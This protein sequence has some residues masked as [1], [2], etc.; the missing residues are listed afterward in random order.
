[1]DSG[2]EPTLPVAVVAVG[3]VLAGRYEVRGVLGAG[4]M[5]AVYRALDRE[6]EEEIALKVLRPELAATPDALKR[7]RREVKLARRVT[8]P[9]VARTYDLSEHAG[10][11][12]LT[13]ELIAG[14]PLSRVVRKD[15]PLA[16]ALRVAVEVARGLAAAHAAGVVHRD[17]KPDNVML[18]GERVVLT[19]FGIA[20]GSES[21]DPLATSAGSVVG[22]PAYMAPEQVEGRAIDGRTD[23]YALGVLLFELLTGELP[24]K[25]DSAMAQAAARLVG[26]PPDPRALRPGL[27]D[28]V[29]RLVVEALSRAREERPAAQ[30]MVERLE[31]L[32]GGGGGLP[33]PA[34]TPSSAVDWA[35]RT[36]AQTLRVRPL[37]APPD[38]TTLARDLGRALID[39]LVA[40]RRVTLVSD[41]S[42]ATDFAL[43]GSVSVAGGRARARVRL[44]DAR[45][46]AP[47]WAERFEAPADDPFA[48]EDALAAA[49]KDVVQSRVAKRQAPVDAK[50]RDRLE[51]A[52][53]S[54][55]S[56]G[57]GPM[58]EAI[59]LLEEIHREAPGEPVVMSL[60]GLAVAKLW[61]M[62]GSVEES[63]IA[64][65][66]ELVLR[67][68]EI[69]PMSADSYNAIAL[70]RSQTGDYRQSLRAAEEALRRSP[71]HAE[72]HYC[73]GRLLCFTGHTLE[74]LRRLEISLRLDPDALM[75]HVERAHTLALLGERDRAARLLDDLRERFGNTA[76]RMLETRWAIWFHDRAL[77]ARL[78]DHMEQN[79]TGAE[80]DKSAPVMR[81]LGNGEPFEHAKALL[82]AITSLR[83]APRHRGMMHQIAAEY[84]GTWG[85]KAEAL[86][87]V[88]RGAALSPFIEVLW[89]DRCPALDVLRSDPRWASVRATVAARAAQIW[90]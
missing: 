50:I 57:P 17:L 52:R 65:S 78:A 31:R 16:D 32:R 64:R 88:E 56:F 74:G 26:A 54:Y 27:V 38:H 1:M 51:K 70:L 15:Y 59:R 2:H 33:E 14:E 29:A 12:F 24:F 45:R 25:G 62:T 90:E 58:R 28:G 22:T 5:G 13:M 67:A 66:E 23:V 72:A 40:E 6:L 43:E 60:L 48:L 63:L 86:D 83:V 85:M 3:E 47:V 41:D 81:A 71:V 21:G 82:D 30:T 76:G 42:A 18:A 68:I 69:D 8:H 46:D 75:P 80:W 77:A 7:F 36:E 87:H 4:G 61:V 84:Y 49:V 9:N 34:R 44:V 37:E 55:K 73:I 39:A 89:L 79:P 35:L 19:D 10:M 20:R 11:R 53:A